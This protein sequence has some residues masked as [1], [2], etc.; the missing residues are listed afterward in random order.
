MRFHQLPLSVLSSFLYLEEQ[1]CLSRA[2]KPFYRLHVQ[3]MLRLEALIMPTIETKLH[4]HFLKSKKFALQVLHKESMWL[5]SATYSTHEQFLIVLTLVR[6]KLLHPKANQGHML[7]EIDQWLASKSMTSFFCLPKRY[8]FCS[9][10]PYQTK[11]KGF[12]IR[13]LL[14]YCQRCTKF[15]PKTK[16][17]ICSSAVCAKCRMC[18]TLCRYHTLPAC[19]KSCLQCQCA[20]CER[21]VCHSNRCRAEIAWG[22]YEALFCKE[23]VRESR[24]I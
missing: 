9:T 22:G 21:V 3:N 14:D 5:T 8:D 17:A 1:A 18:C 19:M 12:Q 15:N 23:C 16:C 20:K 13:K 6:L 2:F 4:S 11:L 24:Y 10:N 7:T